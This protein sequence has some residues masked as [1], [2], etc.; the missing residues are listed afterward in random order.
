MITRF[1]DVKENNCVRFSLQKP[2][3]SFYV[4]DLEPGNVYRVVLFS[5]NAKGRSEPIVLDDISFKGVAKYTSS[6]YC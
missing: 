2:P 1:F 3:V 6:K 4:E 5:S